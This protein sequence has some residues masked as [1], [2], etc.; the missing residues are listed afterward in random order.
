MAEEEELEKQLE[1]Q[2]QEQRDSLSS[3]NE[4]LASDPNNPEFL[5][6]RHL[7]LPRLSFLSFEVS[8]WFL[9]K[10]ICLFTPSRCL[11]FMIDCLIEADDGFPGKRVDYR[12]QFRRNSL[13]SRLSVLNHTV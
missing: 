1:H 12:E 4:V 9:R 10:L 5:A 7:I 2:L 6:V 3:L 11:F 8:V 13:V